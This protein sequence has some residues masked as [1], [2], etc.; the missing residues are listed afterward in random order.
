MVVGYAGSMGLPNALDALLDAAALL[1]GEP[2]HFVLV[3]DGHEKARLAPR[4]AAEGLDNVT[5]LRAVPK[6]QIPALLAA[7]T[8]P[9]SAGS[10]CRSTAS[11]SRRTS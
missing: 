1:R 10:A 4:V 3:G 2:L 11:A 6:A 9:T 7:S 5:L 8:S